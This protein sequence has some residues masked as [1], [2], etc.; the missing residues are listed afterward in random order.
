MERFI[1]FYFYWNKD[2]YK[3]VHNSDKNIEIYNKNFMFN[4]H[5]C[6]IFSVINCVI[7]S[8]LL[9]FIES[10]IYD[11][12]KISW[13]HVYNF[14]LSILSCIVILFCIIQLTFSIF[15]IYVR[16]SNKDRYTNRSLYLSSIS[17]IFATLTST[18][19]SISLLIKEWEIYSASDSVNIVQILYCIYM[20]YCGINISYLL[21]SCVKIG[22]I[23]NLEVETEGQNLEA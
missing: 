6:S 4:I 3:D 20:I 15:Y 10:E 5:F 18:I 11:G 16:I 23:E 9:F 22:Y 7:C 19:L 14:Y 17:H 13:L 21:N 1:T 2:K 12:D 8:I